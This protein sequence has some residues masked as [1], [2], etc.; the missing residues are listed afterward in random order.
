MLRVV[1]HRKGIPCKVQITGLPFLRV[2]EQCQLLLVTYDLGA[3][4]QGECL[5]QGLLGKLKRLAYFDKEEFFDVA[6]KKTRSSVWSSMSMRLEAL[7]FK[8]IL[9]AGRLW[10][11]PSFERR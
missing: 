5:W 11:L 3:L 10:Y 8:A 1:L 2:A 4:A 6:H 7:K 9:P